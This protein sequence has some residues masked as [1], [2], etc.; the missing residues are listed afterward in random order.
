MKGLVLQRIGLSCGLLAPVL[1]A[2]TIVA[3]G[4]LRPGFSHRTQYISELG[5]R[6]SSTELIM[7]YAGFLPTGVMHIAFSAFLFGA[8]KGSRLAAVAAG[9]LA[10]NGCARIAAGV[11][12]CAVGCDGSRGLIDQK[13]H[14]LSGGVGFFALIAAAALWGVVFRSYKG[15]RRLSGYSIGSGLLGLVFLALMSWSAESRAATGLYE[16]LSSGILS[17]WVFTFAAR[18]LQL[19]SFDSP[20]AP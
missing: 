7:R 3:C 11:F 4:T 14:S 2:S 12:P 6:G 8:F 13:L 10:T 19:R 16:R 18:L 9:L 17:L 20:G 1:W 5:E 15:L